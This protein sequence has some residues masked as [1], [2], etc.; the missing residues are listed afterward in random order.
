MKK[1]ILVLSLLALPVIAGLTA[2]GENKVTDSKVE[3]VE[4]EDDNETVVEDSNL[5]NVKF[6]DLSVIADGKEKEIVVSDLP[7]GYTVKY[8]QNKGTVQGRYLAKAKI[9]DANGTLRKVLKAVLIIDNKQNE[10]FEAYL[11]DYFVENL[12]LDAYNWNVF[13]I[14]CSKFGQERSKL[15]AEWY[16]Y[17]KATQKEIDDTVAFYTELKHD[18]EDFKKNGLSFQELYTY[19]DLIVEV[20]SSIE[21]YTGKTPND[22][23]I[24]LNYIDSS[25]GYVSELAQGLQGYNVRT[26]QDALDMVSYVSSTSEAFATYANY[27]QDRLDAGYPLTDTSLNGMI[28][29]LDNVTEQGDNYYLETALDNLIDGCSAISDGDAAQIKSD[30]GRAFDDSFFPAVSALSTSL[31]KFV[32]STTN[33]GYYGNYGDAGKTQYRYDLAKL[34]GV[35]YSKVD[36]AFMKAY[37]AELDNGIKEYYQLTMEANIMLD[38]YKS[39]FQQYINGSLSLIGKDS[40]EDLLAYSKE[41]AKELVYPLESEPEITFREMD[42]TVQEIT[43]TM[44]YYTKSPLDSTSSEYITINPKYTTDLNELLATIAHEGYPG[45]LYAYVLLK[46]QSDLSNYQKISTNKF[47]GEGWAKYVESQ[48]MDY[49]KVRATGNTAAKKACDYIKYNGIMVFLLETRIDAGIAYEGWTVDQVASYLGK[50]GFNSSAAHD[51]YDSLTEIPTTYA[52]YGYGLYEMY[53]LHE[54]ARN[55]LGEAY[56]EKDYNK[57]ILTHGWVGLENLEQLHNEYVSLTKHK[58]N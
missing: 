23:L 9:Y 17:E 51:V 40:Y 44:A 58:A 27:A 42:K 45:H 28:D 41:F 13:T 20:N 38:K 16:S 6:E 56:N 30:L 33:A 57:Y 36:D 4:S 21:Y 22:L 37:I 55:T 26:K 15:T 43:H 3:S 54:N 2:C 47:F 18:L 39:K 19:N 10:E 1:K 31:K 29:Y 49:I 25:G 53:T 48:L 7:E 12:G 35:E 11:N 24:R 8:Y 32:G 52:A 50:N 34:L 46:E 14:D 5:D